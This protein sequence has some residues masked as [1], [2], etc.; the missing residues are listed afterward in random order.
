MSVK[1][2]IASNQAAVWPSQERLT[3]L[4]RMSSRYNFIPLNG[5]KPFIT[6]WQKFSYEKRL[7][8]VNEF[9]R[10]NAGIVTGPSSGILVLDIDSPVLFDC[11]AKSNNLQVPETFTVKTAKGFHKYYNYPDNIEVKGKPF[12]HP[13]LKK[14]S[15]YDKRGVGGQIVAPYSVHPETGDVYEIVNDVAIVDAPAWLSDNDYECDLSVLKF[16]NVSDEANEEFLDSFAPKL[17]SEYIN[18]ITTGTTVGS[19][20]EAIAKVIM[21]LVSVGCDDDLITYVL[22]HFKIGE[23]SRETGSGQIGWIQSEI[24]RCRDS[25]KPYVK[26]SAQPY[27]SI[28]CDPV[29]DSLLLERPDLK[30]YRIPQDYSLSAASGVVLFEMATR[31]K[32]RQP[33]EITA[34]RN[35]VYVSAVYVDIDNS[36][37]A[38]ELTF[39][40]CGSW[41]SIKVDR[42]TVANTSKATSLSM[43]G[44][45][46]TSLSSRYLVEYVSIF[47]SLNE[48]I[49]P[50]FSVTSSLGWDS[51]KNVFLLGNSCIG[52]LPNGSALKFNDLGD[53]TSQIA[54]AFKISGSYQEWVEMVNLVKDYPLIVSYIF[55]SFVPPI[56]DIIGADNFIYDIAHQTSSGKSITMMLAASAWGDPDKNHDASVVHTWNNTK[57]WTGTAA[58]VFRAIPLFL[59]DTKQA[60]KG[61]GLAQDSS[62]ISNIIYEITGGKGKGRGTPTGIQR[63]KSWKTVLMSNG[64]QK[65]TQYSEGH[66][67]AAARCVS[68]WGSPFGST[69][70]RQFVD[71]LKDLACINYGHAADRYIKYLLS[72]KHNW[73]DWKQEYAQI[74]DKLS[75]RAGSNNAA[76]RISKYLASIVAAGF[77]MKKAMPELAFL[78][79]GTIVDSLW[80]SVVD[81]SE[82]SDVA[83]E[84]M[85]YLHSFAI[86]NQDSFFGLNE[87]KS[88][89]KYYGRWDNGSDH[90]SF[91]SKGLKECIEKRFEFSAVINI[92]YDRGWIITKKKGKKTYSVKINNKPA[93]CYTFSVKHMEELITS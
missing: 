14:V 29:E 46:V 36:T 60:L 23:K 40:E 73:Y 54:E 92:W 70:D 31:G 43:Y 90:I 39:R 6:E 76:G 85:K 88:T 50:R 30:D 86:E 65:I 80:S 57:A 41:K 47:M 72:E 18:L 66:G 8:D 10:H 82:E 59:D 75:Q 44:I 35:V 74:A 71:K 63:K 78:N 42:E 49:I 15:V 53:G 16:A 5:K 52:Q 20:S 51:A 1:Q 87:D 9:I 21:K 28:D 56:L 4:T 38:V 55:G 89:R 12:K 62:T 32:S 27:S 3:W 64:E 17:G 79:P 91:T 81:G 67:G 7:F 13:I 37:Q 19:R 77:I 22:L 11:L 84:A 61:N 93:E 25:F 68:C 48:D 24:R 2:K 69:N 83:K 26:S 58:S 33:V 34:S 45:N